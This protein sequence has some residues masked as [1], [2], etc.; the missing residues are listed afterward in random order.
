MTGLPVLAGTGAMGGPIGTHLLEKGTNLA[1][2]DLAPAKVAFLAAKLCGPRLT[3]R[4]SS[5]GW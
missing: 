2:F 4:T 1:V 3:I 5:P